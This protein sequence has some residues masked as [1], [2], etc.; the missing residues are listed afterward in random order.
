M[1]R[2]EER[3]V[4]EVFSSCGPEKYPKNESGECI[5][6]RIFNSNNQVLPQSFLNKEDAESVCSKLNDQYDAVFLAK[7]EAIEKAKEKL[8]ATS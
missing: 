5:W 8:E 6:Y 7:T 2:V 3:I 1:Y 4:N